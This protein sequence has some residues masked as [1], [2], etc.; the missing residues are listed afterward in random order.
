M[1]VTLI[2]QITPFGHQVVNY[3]KTQQNATYKLQLLAIRLL[4]TSKDLEKLTT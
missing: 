3:S 2:I 4:T 1:Q